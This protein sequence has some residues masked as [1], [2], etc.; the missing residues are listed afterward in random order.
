VSE[1]SDGH[2]QMLFRA[3]SADGRQCGAR[4]KR[5]DQPDPHRRTLPQIRR[6]SVVLAASLSL[7]S[8]RVKV[9]RTVLLARIG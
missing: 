5:L 6:P 2:G 3:S 8:N 9:S 1:D 4:P 7:G